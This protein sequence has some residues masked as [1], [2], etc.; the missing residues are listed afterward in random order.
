MSLSITSRGAVSP[1][2]LSVT[3]PQ[4]GPAQP[5]PRRAKAE[6]GP[7]AGY[8]RVGDAEPSQIYSKTTRKMQ[9]ESGSPDSDSAAVAQAAA[10]SVTPPTSFGAHDHREAVRIATETETARSALSAWQNAT[11]SGT[12]HADALAITRPE[13]SLQIAQNP[14]LAA[15]NAAYAMIAGGFAQA[16]PSPLRAA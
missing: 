3:P 5:Q 1:V 7:D 2:G 14:Q 9:P 16:T 8:V 4:T 15:A 12:A 6:T 13:N 10:E 11:E